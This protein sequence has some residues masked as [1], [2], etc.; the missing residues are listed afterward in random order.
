MVKLLKYGF[1]T[2]VV[3]V[4][5]LLA[6][7]TMLYWSA[8][9]QQP[10]IAVDTASVEVQKVGDSVR[11]SQRARLVLNRYGVWE[12][13]MSGDPIER[14]LHIGVVGSDLLRGQEEAF[15]ASIR[16]FVPSKRYLWLLHKL[17]IIF[18]RRMARHIPEELRTEIYAMSASCSHDLDIFG[19]PYERQINY[20]AAHDI[21]HAMQEYMLVGCSAFAVRGEASADG[22]LLIG[23]NFD[24]YVGEEFAKNKLLLAVAPDKGYRFV[25]VTWPGMLGVVSGMNECGLTVTINA[26]KGAIPTSSA[27]PI[28]LLARQ[29]LQYAATLDEAYA[30]ASEAQTFVSESLLIGSGD[31]CRAIVIEKSPTQTARYEAPGDHLVVTNHFQSEAFATDG[32]NV[33][34]IASSDSPYRHA[35]ICELLDEQGPLTAERAAYILRNRYGLGGKDIGLG[36]E[37][38]LN[39]AIAHHAVIFQPKS[40]RMWLSTAPWQVGAMLCYDFESLFADDDPARER[41]NEALTIAPDS[42]FLS[43]DYPRIEAYRALS[44]QLKQGGDVALVDSLIELNPHYWGAYDVAAQRYIEAGD[45]ERAVE[46]WRKALACE[47]ARLGERQTIEKNINHYGKR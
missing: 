34:N 19:T 25:S 3:F 36:N 10:T 43:E 42:R 46:A 21:G 17:T 4:A 26:A 31:E 27:M 20:H 37:K 40:R 14:G 39:Q 23:R 45:T 16:R 38:S 9:M 30:L 22:E 12:A 15:V 5:V 1:W 18:N 28:S 24:F 6:V 2:L 44:E 32:Y 7:P 8:D 47:I 13:A 33:A 11:Y 35:R 41:F 29:I